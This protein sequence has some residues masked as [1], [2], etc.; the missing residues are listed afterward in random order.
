MRRDLD[1]VRAAVADGAGLTDP[2]KAFHSMTVVHYAARAGAIPVL[3]H[4][5]DEGVDL[6]A[7]NSQG[8]TALAAACGAN[9]PAT[10]CV[11]LALRVRQDVLDKVHAR[12]VDGWGV[13]DH[14]AFFVCVCLGWMC[15]MCVCVFACMYV[16]VRVCVSTARLHATGVPDADWGRVA[17]GRHVSGVCVSMLSWRALHSDA[18]RHTVFCLFPPPARRHRAAA[19]GGYGNPERGV[20]PCPASRR[21]GVHTPRHYSVFQ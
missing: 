4:L 18:F 11:L 20:A 19:H 13:V 16:C 8:V 3:L 15:Q 10:A 12:H 2:D 14:D 1:G 6:N 17:V 9:C 7:G 5:H 21:A